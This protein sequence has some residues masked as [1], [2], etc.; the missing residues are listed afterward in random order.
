MAKKLNPPNFAYDVFNVTNSDFYN[1]DFAND[2][3]AF[4]NPYAI[5]LLDNPVAKK[6]QELQ[7]TFLIPLEN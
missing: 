1:V 3:R 2:N 4:L 6:Q 5:E 7:L